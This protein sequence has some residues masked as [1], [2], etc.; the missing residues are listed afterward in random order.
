MVPLPDKREPYDHQ[1]WTE[2]ASDQRQPYDRRR[3]MDAMRE[4]IAVLR[5]QIQTGPR[6]VR[7]VESRLAETKAQLEKA[8]LK[9]QKL[10]EVIE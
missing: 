6:P 1:R 5:R 8:H 3:Q 4:E 10:T 7:M 9:N 2:P